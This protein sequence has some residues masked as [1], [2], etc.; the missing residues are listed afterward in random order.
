MMKI[1]Q[2]L[3]IAFL[4][5]SACKKDKN[6][7]SPDS[8]NG[9]WE[10]RQIN[11]G[12]TSG[13]FQPGNNNIIQFSGT[14]FERYDEGKRTVT[15]TFQVVDEKAEV[16]GKTVS[17]KI[18]FSSGDTVTEAFISRVGKTLTIYYGQIAADGAEL[19]YAKR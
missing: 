2:F 3:V 10:L 4:L 8:L 12:W 14:S 11:G 16:N 1:C 15:G 9:T 7:V 13:E 5:F 19:T 17:Q 6:N 18:I